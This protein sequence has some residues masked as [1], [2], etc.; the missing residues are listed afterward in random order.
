VVNVSTGL[1]EMALLYALPV[2]GPQGFYG[3]MHQVL[4]ERLLDAASELICSEGWDA[5][6]MTQVARMVG[7]SRQAAYKQFSGKA[8]LG[9][10]VVT[11]ET[12][13]VLAGVTSRMRAHGADPVAGITAAAGYVLRAAAISPLIKALLTDGRAGAP[14]LLPLVTTRPEPVLARAI[15]AVAA[16]AQQ[17][18]GALPID[19]QAITRLSEIIVRLTLSHLVQPTGP[20]DEALAQIRLLIENALATLT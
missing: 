9:E 10:A 14:G 5:L 19:S 3:Q 6:G 4:R 12:D 13:R 20:V 1:A 8:A 2:G 18:Y 11:R 15:A 16:E 7:V 17:C